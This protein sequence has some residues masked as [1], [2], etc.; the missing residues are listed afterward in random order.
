MIIN[1]SFFRLSSG[2]ILVIFFLLLFTF[3]PV[4]KIH[5]FNDNKFSMDLLLKIQKYI[6]KFIRY[7]KKKLMELKNVDL[8][9]SMNYTNI[10]FYKIIQIFL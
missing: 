4:R 8:Y 6:N 5:K 10:Y 1:L 9:I 3:L 2:K 7:S